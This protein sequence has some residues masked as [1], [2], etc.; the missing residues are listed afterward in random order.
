MNSLIETIFTDFEV[1]GVKI[2]V[3]FLTYEGKSTT[4]ITYLHEDTDNAFGGDNEILGYVNYYDFNIYSKGN[5][6]KIIESV[7]KIMKQNGFTW[8]PSRGSSDMYELET[9]YFHKTLSFAIEI[10][11]EE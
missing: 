8:Q 10:E 11:E 7:K 4:Y 5:Y 6:L 1:D 3:S 2:P 9:G